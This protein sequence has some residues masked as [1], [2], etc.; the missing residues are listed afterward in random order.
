MFGGGENPHGIWFFEST[1]IVAGENLSG[2]IDFLNK[3]KLTLDNVN[4]HGIIR[5]YMGCSSNRRVY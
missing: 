2:V 3:Q 4:A 1:W 5:I